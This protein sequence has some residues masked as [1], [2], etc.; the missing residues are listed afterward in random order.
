MSRREVL[1]LIYEQQEKT[2]ERVSSA[3]EKYRKG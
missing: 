3:I 1:D 2:N